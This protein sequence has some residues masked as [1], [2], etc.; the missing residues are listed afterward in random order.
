MTTHDT[1]RDPRLDT[2]QRALEEGL[3]SIAAAR[4]PAEAAAARHRAR[5]RLE[6]LGFRAARVAADD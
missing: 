1:P 4:S 6:S 3:Q 2:L 5:A